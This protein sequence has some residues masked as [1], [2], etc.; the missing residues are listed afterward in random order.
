LNQKVGLKFFEAVDFELRFVIIIE[1]M[2]FYLKFIKNT[3]FDVKST[4]LK[5]F[6]PTF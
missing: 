1:S 4:A 3:N 6:K 5:N 2:N